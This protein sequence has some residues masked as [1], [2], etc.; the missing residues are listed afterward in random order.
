MRK[1]LLA[2][3]L[4][5]IL[6]LQATADSKEVGKTVL[7]DVQP[8][9]PT[10]KHQQYDLSITTNSGKEYTCRTKRDDKVK[11]TDLVVG[12]DVSYEIKGDKG[13]IK[14]AANKKFECT[15]VRVANSSGAAK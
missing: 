6:T 3:A 10:D 7:K 11:A 15:I 4:I 8:T 2:I 12:G 14:T 13:K 9:G 1:L 5:G